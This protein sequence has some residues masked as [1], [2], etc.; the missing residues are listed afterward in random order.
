MCI[1]ID[2]CDNCEISFTD[3]HYG[4]TGLY[5]LNQKLRQYT[6]Y[7]AKLRLKL[8]PEERQKQDANPQPEAHSHVA[9]VTPMID[10]P[11]VGHEDGEVSSV[12][13]RW[14]LYYTFV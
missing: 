7:V 9:M 5:I 1:C 8:P 2:I 6:E 12:K 13:N 4:S 3:E 11:D 10:E 14:M